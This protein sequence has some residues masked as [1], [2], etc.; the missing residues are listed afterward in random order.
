MER[1]LCCEVISS[2]DNSN[3]NKKNNVYGNTSLHIASVHD[4]L[5]C[6][7]ILVSLDETSAIIKNNNGWTPLHYAAK[8]GYLE[9][10]KVLIDLDETGANINEK[11]NYDRSP[12]D[13]L[14]EKN[15]LIIEEYITLIKDPLLVKGVVEDF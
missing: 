5:E 7:K 1:K 12:L 6:V 14:S 3:I 4:H 11:D 2:G 9:C 13:Y 15:S 10:M 8:Y